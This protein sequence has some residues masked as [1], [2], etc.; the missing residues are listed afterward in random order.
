MYEKVFELFIMCT[1]NVTVVFQRIQFSAYY[2]TI[3]FI[4]PCY[5]QT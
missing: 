3:I 5:L 4:I 2:H 1:V